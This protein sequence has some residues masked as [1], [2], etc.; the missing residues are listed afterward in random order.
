MCNYIG[1]ELSKPSFTSSLSRKGEKIAKSVF[2]NTSS[3]SRKTFSST[4]HKTRHQNDVT[5][6][7]HFQTPTL[8]KS[9]L[10]PWLKHA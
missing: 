4:P 2:L 3:K 10:R 6:I 1:L 8:A 5:K 9:W 7:F